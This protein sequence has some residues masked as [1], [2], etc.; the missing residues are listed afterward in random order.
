MS[1]FDI[2]FVDSQYEGGSEE[3]KLERFASEA[4][5]W[6]IYKYKGSEGG[7]YTNY[8]A[9]SHPGDPQEQ[10]MFQSPYVHDPVLVY[11]RAS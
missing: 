9:I 3:E 10:A 11:E 1:S 4:G 6:R 5:Y 7:D 2:S 8:K